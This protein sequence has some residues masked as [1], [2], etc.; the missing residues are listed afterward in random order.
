MKTA[1]SVLFLVL[2]LNV[3]TA[4]TD[5]PQPQM[6]ADNL[7]DVTLDGCNSVFLV[8]DSGV[9]VVDA[10]ISPMDGYNL[11]SSISSVT[12]KPVKYVL[13]THHHFDHV[14]GVQVFLPGARVIAAAGLYNNMQNSGKK[15]FDDFIA[16]MDS[17]FENY[18]KKTAAL[19]SKYMESGEKE[20]ADSIQANISF[21]G[22]Y[23]DSCKAVR[24]F[25]PDVEFKKSYTLKFG[26]HKIMLTHPGP[27][28][29]GSDCIVYFPE[30]HVV[31]LGDLYLEKTFPLIDKPAGASIDS[32]IKILKKLAGNKKY[33]HLIC[34]HGQISN[35]S[36]LLVMRQL[37][38]DINEAIRSTQYSL[39]MPRVEAIFVKIADKYPEYYA[40][41]ILE[42]DI[43]MLLD[44]DIIPAFY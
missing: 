14:G 27:A 32:W 41:D 15:L 5:Y 28:H 12:D 10:G 29:T 23:I 21:F 18:K 39:T 13:I 1:F 3:L 25:K 31:H 22:S 24:I 17:L 43:R 36:D 4:Q 20:K 35:R 44:F 26:G 37:L 7:Y 11:K 16:E 34:G 38:V 8:T 6:I 19:I 2:L 9:V 33:E 30:F 40:P 42:K